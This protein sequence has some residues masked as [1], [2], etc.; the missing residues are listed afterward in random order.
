MKIICVGKNYELHVK[1]FD[2]VVPSE[3][4]IFIKPDSAL[5]LKN[6][7]F[8]LPDFSNEIH[9]E[10]ELV[11]RINKLGKNISKKFAHRYYE[12]IGIGIDF[13]ARDL[14]RE[15]KKRGLPWEKAKSFDGAA[16]LGDFISKEKFADLQNISFSLQKN[17]VEVQHGN[18][19]DMLFTIDEIIEHVSSFMTLKI[20]D[21]IY[22][23]TPEGVGS[24]AVGD[25][26]KAYIEDEL[27]L[28]FEVK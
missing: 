4:V 20:G 16:V 6:R 21:Y 11:V 19:K 12:E 5:L 15:L 13:T 28:D 2:G 8:Y 24:V 27:L 25:T 22:T 23:G 26:L 3:P 1:E 9:H 18:S 14:Q 17:N 10:V 7:P